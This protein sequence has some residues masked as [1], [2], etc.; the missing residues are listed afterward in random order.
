MQVYMLINKSVNI[1]FTFAQY[2]LPKL[3]FTIVGELKIILYFSTNPQPYNK[4]LHILINII[5]SMEKQN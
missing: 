4:F 5:M 1:E 2:N 3:R